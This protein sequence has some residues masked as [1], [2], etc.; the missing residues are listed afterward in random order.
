MAAAVVNGDR[1][2]LA[3]RELAYDPQWDRTAFQQSLR[4]IGLQISLQIELID[5]DFERRPPG[6]WNIKSVS[7]RCKVS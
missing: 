3:S 6:E 7:I 2:G 4:Q 1:H 5:T